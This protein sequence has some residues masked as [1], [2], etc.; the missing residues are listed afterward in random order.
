[1]LK[2]SQMKDVEVLEPPTARFKRSDK[3]KPV[4]SWLESLNMG[5]V[6]GARAIEVWLETNPILRAELLEKHTRHHLFH[7][8]QKCHTNI[9][10]KKK[11]KV[12]NGVVVRSIILLKLI[13]SILHIDFSGKIHAIL[14]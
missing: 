11:K 13:C 10:K 5:S 14:I 7:Y 3:W 6:V 9:I 8:I 12:L 4:Y 1:M 2:F